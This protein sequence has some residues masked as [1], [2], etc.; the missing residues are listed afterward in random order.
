MRY[1]AY[2]NSTCVDAVLEKYPLQK[3]FNSTTYQKEGDDFTYN[4]E[5][6]KA[7]GAQ[8]IANNASTVPKAPILATHCA[9]DT[10]VSDVR[11]ET[12]WN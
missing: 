10:I 3:F 9:T 11:K 1:S 4:E 8:T 5:F 7:F 2:S 6:Q 12:S